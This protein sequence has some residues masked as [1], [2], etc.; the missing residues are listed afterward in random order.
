MHI[1]IINN[2]TLARVLSIRSRS[3]R[4]GSKVAVTRKSLFRKGGGG[5]LCVSE[6]LGRV[7][8]GR[9]PLEREKATASRAFIFSFAGYITRETLSCTLN[10]K[11]AGML[12]LP[13]IRDSDSVIMRRK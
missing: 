12:L 1:V 7:K 6:F 3:E 5:E 8:L 2:N 4:D 10:S 11:I 13:E 9:E